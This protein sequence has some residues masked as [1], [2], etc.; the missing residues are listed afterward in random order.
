MNDSNK[1]LTMSI[2]NVDRVCL[3]R[4]DSHVCIY[5][6]RVVCVKSNVMI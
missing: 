4:D 2:I 3:R 6:Q 5:I 1:I